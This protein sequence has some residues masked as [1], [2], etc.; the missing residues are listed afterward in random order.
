VYRQIKQASDNKTKTTKPINK[1]NNNN[2]RK[3]VLRAAEELVPISAPWPLPALLGL[4]STYW[5][6]IA[7]LV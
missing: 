3:K 5:K 6:G 2:K 7:A 1:S 4:Y